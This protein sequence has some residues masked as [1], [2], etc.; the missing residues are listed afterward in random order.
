MLGQRFRDKVIIRKRMIIAFGFFCFIFFMLLFRLTYIMIL[1]SKD[2][3]ALAE[4]QWTSTVKIDARR[5]KILDRNGK[6]LAISANVYRV[7][8]DLN[9]IK[10]YL[11]KNNLS[12]DDIAPKIAQAMNMDISKV[13]KALNTRLPSGAPAGSANLARRIEKQE[14]D[15]VRGLFISGVLVSPDTKRYYPNNNFLAH[16]LG[17]TNVDGKGLTGI[18]LQY[19]RELTGV[20]GVRIA[21]IDRRSNELPY[22]ISE[23]TEPIDG[24]DIYLTIDE[25]I[26]Y[27]CEKAADQALI[28][29]KAK[30]VSIMAMD[31]KTGEILAM[32]NKPDFNPNNSREQTSSFE[33]LQKLWRN[34]AVNDTYEP[35][36][37]FKVVTA[38]AAIEEGLVHENDKFVCG[39]S[40]KVANRTI[41]CWKRTGHGTQSFVDI[42]K[43]SC[44]V[45][46]IN[47]GQKLGKEKL[48]KYISLFGLGQKT[49]IDLPGEAKGIVKKTSSINDVDLATISFGQTNTVNP[50][51]F[52]AAFNAVANNGVWVK[53]HLMKEVSY[54]DNNNNKVLYKAFDDSVNKRVASEEN[55]KLLRSYL[56]KVISEGSGKRAFIEGYHIGG[57][58]GTAQKVNSQ[59]GTY[60]RGKYVSSFVGMAPA[61]NPRISIFISIDEP[62]AGEYYA[63]VITTPIAKQVFNDIFNYLAIEADA[64]DAS[65]TRSL[66]KDVII[67]EVRGLKKEEAVKILKANNLNYELDKNNNIITDISPKPGITVKEGT[68]IILYT[69]Q[70]ANYNKEVVV[71]D[72]KGYSKEKAMEILKSI[73]LKAKFTGEGVVMEQSIEPEQKVSKDTVLDIILD[74][75]GG[76]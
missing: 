42:L 47:I 66:L 11:A 39:G 23:Y 61:Q 35:G 44:N 31:T 24:K 46:F 34:R 69:S 38:I 76:D 40:I 37:I 75:T 6:E 72:L 17:N 63:G 16:V 58:T 13:L 28:D 9:T 64:D 29:N 41:H 4:E 27:F 59:N 43:N 3:Y 49:G 54:I 8:F 52:L 25:K 67:P 55:T 5:G 30:A 71:P 62:S 45:G 32:V 57:K 33:E 22:T 2:Y 48:N 1:K 12:N 70:E 15:K 10:Q 51:Q 60:E 7:D 73:G 21:E 65:V 20:P 68:K 26:Q 18:E 74:L 36:S 19:D 56:E 53:P 14:A 50:V